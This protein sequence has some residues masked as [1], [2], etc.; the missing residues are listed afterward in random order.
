MFLNLPHNVAPHG[1]P[2]PSQ[3]T[4]PYPD[5]GVNCAKIHVERHAREATD[6]DSV[7][8]AGVATAP[9]RAASMISERMALAVGKGPAP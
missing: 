7:S 4:L 3:S 2:V 5:P 1:S 8:S 6:Q 9:T